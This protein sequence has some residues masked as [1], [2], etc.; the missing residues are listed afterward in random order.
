[1][2]DEGFLTIKPR[3]MKLAEELKALSHKEFKRRFYK[4]ECSKL[5]QE[6]GEAFIWENGIHDLITLMESFG[7]TLTREEAEK[8]YEKAALS[9]EQAFKKDH[10]QHNTRNV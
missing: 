2:N 7:V 6:D 8:E 1:M 5:P 4:I 10:E 9:V 3:N